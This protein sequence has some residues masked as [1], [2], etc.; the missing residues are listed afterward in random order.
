MRNLYST[1][2][3]KVRQSRFRYHIRILFISEVFLRRD[4]LVHDLVEDEQMHTGPAKFFRERKGATGNF[5]QRSFGGIERIRPLINE[6][7]VFILNGGVGYKDVARL[8][9]PE[10]IDYALLSVF[11][12]IILICF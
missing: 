10:A 6:K 9:E 2:C 1:A 11:S 8:Q 7:Y 12:A 3:T 4:L 5:N